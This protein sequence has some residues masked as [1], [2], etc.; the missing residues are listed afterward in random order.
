MSEQGDRI[1]TNV[2]VAATVAFEGREIVKP[3]PIDSCIAGIVATL[4]ANGLRMLASCCGHGKVPGTILLLDGTT[5]TIPHILA[6]S[7]HEAS[8]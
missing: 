2:H 7:E 3:M 4:D 8:A 1:L 6:D 5:I